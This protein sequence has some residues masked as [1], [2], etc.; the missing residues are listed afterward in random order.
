MASANETDGTNCAPASSIMSISA[1]TP[2]PDGAD[3]NFSTI[4]KRIHSLSKFVRFFPQRRERFEKVM[5]FIQPE[6]RE[7]N[8]KCLEINVSTR[9]NSTY[10]MF[11]QAILLQK[12]CTHFC[13][14]DQEVQPY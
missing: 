12:T 9:W 13:Q 10:S 4:L 5:D 8:I 2:Q 14:E 11:K 7:K 6:M 1:L 3:V